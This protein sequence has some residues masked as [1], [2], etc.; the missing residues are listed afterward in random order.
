VESVAVGAKV[1]GF[2]RARRGAVRSMAAGQ[3]VG[4]DKFPE[5]VLIGILEDFPD[6]PVHAAIF[7][8]GMP[9]DFSGCAAT[10]CCR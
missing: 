5:V 3:I 6:R 7:R 2:F 8:D 10:G 4:C 9:E 1:A